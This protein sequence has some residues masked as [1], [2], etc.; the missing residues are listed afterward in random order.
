MSVLT[1][2]EIHAR[3]AV[4]DWAAEMLRF[5]ATRQPCPTWCDGT[6]ETVGHNGDAV[7]H[8]H[9][10]VA[11]E[12]EADY[13]VGPPGKVTVQSSRIDQIDGSSVYG[14]ELSVRDAET[15]MGD[16]ATLTAAQARKL[17]RELDAAAS[18]ID[19]AALVV[20]QHTGGTR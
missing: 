16:F 8:T 14:I 6:C 13:L 19:Q 17:A 5:D 11:V 12:S 3:P 15:V 2:E 7:I 1:L 20:G 18:R 10:L 4:K 9:E